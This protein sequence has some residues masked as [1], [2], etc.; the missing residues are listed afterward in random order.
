MQNHRCAFL[1]RELSQ[2]TFVLFGIFWPRASLVALFN[3]F[4]TTYPP[5]SVICESSLI[6]F[7]FSSSVQNGSF[8]FCWQSI[9]KF[10]DEMGQSVQLPFQKKKDWFL[11]TP[12]MHYSCSSLP[13]RSRVVG[14]GEGRG[15][16]YPPTL[17]S[18]D[19]GKN[20]SKKNL[21]GLLLAPLDFQT[22]L[23]PC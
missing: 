1:V 12:L 15:Y 16:T 9:F 19:F 3:V 17:P 13:L 11:S 20:R 7:N 14:A 2:I 10:A 8:I 22:F 23:Q 6:V 21:L 18:S 5:L 4:L